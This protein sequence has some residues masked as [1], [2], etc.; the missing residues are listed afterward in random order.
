MRNRNGLVIEEIDNLPG[1]SQIA[2]SHGVFVPK[3]HRG[4]GKGGDA[5]TERLATMSDLG[6]DYALCTVDA[7]NTAQIKILKKNNWKKLDKFVSSK[8]GHKIALYGKFL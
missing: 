5:H 2:V 6:Y 4:T 7:A 8:T 3:E 1:C